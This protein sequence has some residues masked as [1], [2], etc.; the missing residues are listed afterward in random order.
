MDPLPSG[1]RPSR[2]DDDPDFP[3]HAITQRPM[4][5]YHSWGSQNAWL[6][7]IHGTNVLYLP[8][9]VWDAQGFRDGDWARV[10]SPHG[11]ITVPVARMAALNPH[12]VWTWNAIG[13]RR[14]AWA[15]SPTRPRRPD[16]LPP[17]PPDPRT[18]PGGT[19]QRRPGHRPGR[20]VRPPRPGRT[21]DRRPPRPRPPGP[22]PPR[23]SRFPRALAAPE[24][25]PP[26]TIPI[27]TNIPGRLREGQ[28][29][30]RPTPPMTTLPPRPP[31]QARPR[32]RP[33][34]LRRLPGLR[35]RLQGLEHALPTPLSD[36]DP[37]RR[38][39]GGRLPEPRP[40]LRGRRRIK[41]PPPRPLPEILP[42]LR[43][44]ALR[45][46][47]PHRGQLQARDDG[48]VLVNESACIGCGLCAWACPY[49]AREMDPS[50]KVMK[51][52]TLCVDR[53]Y[54]GHPARRR[55]HP[56]LRPHLPR[57]RAPL[58]RPRRSRQRRLPA[59]WPTGA[60]ST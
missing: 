7:Q 45:H 12:T 4:A 2:T 57:R 38:R 10:T 3:L 21:P 44:R 37:L 8:T 22:A 15:L 60:A 11:E 40:Q 39:P 51:K 19:L 53:I 25:S 35:H 14:G 46:R 5:M 6:R 56:R 49:G 42:A 36:A 26:M 17:Q 55:P 16:G 52:C 27:R 1:T 24:G 13:K 47:L 28:R 43:H 34:H 20:L 32:H 18:L 50:A 48:I 33:R 29:P 41:A 30:S 23:R 9:A 58:R 59:W 54:L 31:P